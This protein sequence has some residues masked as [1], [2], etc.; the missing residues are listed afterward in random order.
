MGLCLSNV[1]SGVVSKGLG[2]FVL[3]I[4]V[5]SLGLLVSCGFLHGVSP[6]PTPPPVRPEPVEHRSPLPNPRAQPT[7]TS[8]TALLGPAPITDTTYLHEPFA[9]EQ[10]GTCHDLLNR[11]NPKA[12]WG[13]VVE[14]CRVCHWQTLDAPQP[15]YVHDPYPEGKCLSCHDPHASGQPFLLT[16]PQPDTCLGCHEDFPPDGQPHPKLAAGE[17]LLCHADHGS[18]QP[19]LLRQAQLPLCGRCHADHI[20][21]GPV[22]AAHLKDEAQECAR[23]HDPHTGKLRPDLATKG[24]GACHDELLSATPPVRHKPVEEKQD[25]L[26]CHVFHQRTHVD[27]LRDDLPRACTR[28]HEEGRPLQQPHPKLA[29]N[30]CLLCHTGHGGREA[31]LLRYDERTLCG[32]CHAEQVTPAS[33]QVKEH[34]RDRELPRCDACHDA[35]QGNLRDPSAVTE[36]CGHCHRDEFP[37]T[38]LATAPEGVHK[39][40]REKGCTACHKFHTAERK[41]PLDEDVNTHCLGC[42]EKLQHGGHPVSGKRDVWHGGPLTCVSCHAAHDSPYEAELLLPGDALCL[43]CHTLQVVKER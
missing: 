7:S 31:A 41:R 34:F 10:C 36:A 22:F 32:K 23:C 14:V 24:C 15:A 11:E 26:A 9:L 13:P 17:C 43:K 4:G 37:S 25:C 20:A 38:A 8:A 16:K 2:R 18:D 40:L 6:T 33:Q 27:L 19:G 5:A 35:H 3:A 30:E 39:P 12:L 21:R 42:H 28:C 29:A 1:R